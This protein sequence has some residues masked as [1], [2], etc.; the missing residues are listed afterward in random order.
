MAVVFMAAVLVSRLYGSSFD[1]QALWQLFLRQL[2][3]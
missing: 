3:W 2:F 1:R